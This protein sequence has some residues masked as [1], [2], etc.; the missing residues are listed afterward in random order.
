MPTA[1]PTALVVQRSSLTLA[2]EPRRLSSKWCVLVGRGREATLGSRLPSE[3][4]HHAR[5][6][7]AGA[8]QQYGDVWVF[9]RFEHAF[10]GVA[11]QGNE[12]VRLVDRELHDAVNCGGCESVILPS[13]QVRYSSAVCDDATAGT[14]ISQPFSLPLQI[15]ECTIIY[16]VFFFYI[17]IYT[18]LLI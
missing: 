18:Y 4:Q 3:H 9:Q 8:A 14:I 2:A 7:P 5:E 1:A 12:G 10:V 15:C 13:F 16:I 11:R 17:Y 6:C